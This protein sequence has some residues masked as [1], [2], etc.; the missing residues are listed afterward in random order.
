M[1][2]IK[3]HAIVK[4]LKNRALRNDPE[5]IK[6]ICSVLEN[7]D[8][9]I[10]KVGE[11]VVGAKTDNALEE[12]NEAVDRAQNPEKEEDEDENDDGDLGF[13]S[14][15][16]EDADIEEEEDEEDSSY[17]FV[18]VDDDDDEEDERG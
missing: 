14:E 6:A 15:E 10:D 12:L 4:T 5:I 2:I 1:G 17:T 18:D 7:L 3:D 11:L 16:D 8:N 13:G 9:D